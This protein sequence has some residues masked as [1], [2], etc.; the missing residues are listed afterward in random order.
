VAYQR[1]ELANDVEQA[2]PLVEA[3]GALPRLHVL[4][5]AY[6]PGQDG[7]GQPGLERLA[8]KPSVDEATP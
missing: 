1:E 2:Q 3:V 8:L 4:G 6:E 7:G 5:L